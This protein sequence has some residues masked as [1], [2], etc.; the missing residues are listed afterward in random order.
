MWASQFKNENEILLMVTDLNTK[1]DV[2]QVNIIAKI[3][4][5]NH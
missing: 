4:W 1:I 2:L 3:I 5:Y